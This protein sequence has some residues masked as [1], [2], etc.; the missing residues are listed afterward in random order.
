MSD[1]HSLVIKTSWEPD[2]NEFLT[3]LGIIPGALGEKFFG[4]VYDAL[5][6]TSVE[7]KSEFKKYY[8]VEYA[9]FATYLEIRYGEYLDDKEED[10]ERVYIVVDCL[11]QVLDVAYED[12]KLDTVLKCISKLSEAQDENKI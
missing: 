8:S 12:S 6:V 7:A 11:P 2:R 1:Y 10:V 4:E 3:A 5:F 9:D